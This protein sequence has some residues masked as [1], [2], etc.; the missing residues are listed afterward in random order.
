MDAV[1]TSS[2]G[3]TLKEKIEECHPSPSQLYF[4]SRSSA[5]LEELQYNAFDFLEKHEDPTNCH[6]YFVAGVC[7]ITYRDRHGSYDEVYFIE[8][9]HD[10]IT[11]IKNLIDSISLDI[12]AYGAKPCFAT[13]IPSCLEKWNFH[14]LANHKTSHLLHFHQYSDMQQL[15]NSTILEINRHIITTNKANLMETPL[16]ASTIITQRQLSPGRFHFSRLADGVH[17]TKDLSEQWVARLKKS[18]ANNRYFC[19][20]DLSAWDEIPDR[21]Y[22]EK[23]WSKRSWALS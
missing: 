6:V 5:K 20:P 14:R 23:D 7:D 3:H 12:L 2:R 11:R 13:I 8:S 10:T 15:L 9:P 4:Y 18:M 21:V 1:L 16:L 22:K 17:P 19:T